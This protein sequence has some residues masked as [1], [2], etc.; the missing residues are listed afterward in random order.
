MVVPSV[1]CSTV[2]SPAPLRIFV[3]SSNGA[4]T[5]GVGAAGATPEE[6]SVRM[7]TRAS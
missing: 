1:S 6:V 3:C 5:S 7:S 4:S 2:S